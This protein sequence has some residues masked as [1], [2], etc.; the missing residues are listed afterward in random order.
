MS[1]YISLVD[2]TRGDTTESVH[3]GAV[4]V[5]DTRG[6]VVAQAGNPHVVTFTR[7]SLKP[8]QAMPFVSRCGPAKLGCT[9]PD[10][11]VMSASHNW[12]L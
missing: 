7:S 5:V 3:F 12:E 8:L 9:Q 1:D 11:A 6:R 2:V 4:A 10:L